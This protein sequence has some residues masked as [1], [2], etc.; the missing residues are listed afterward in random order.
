MLRYRKLRRIAVK[1]QLS[2][3]SRSLTV[4]VLALM[5]GYTEL[6]QSAAQAAY[7]YNISQISPVALTMEQLAAILNEDH[8]A[9]PN[10]PY[11]DTYQ[12]TTIND[13]TNAIAS[14][15]PLKVVQTDDP[16]H[17]YLGVFHN[18]VT[19]TEFA[20]FAAYSLDLNTWHTIGTID[21]VAAGEYGSQPDVRILPD[22]SVL[23]AEEYNPASKPQIRVRYY[24]KTG[25]RTGLQLFIADPGTVPS[26]EK[27]LPNIAFSK[28]EG[29]PDFGRI[30]YGG[31]VL[32]SKIEISHYSDFGIRNIQALGTLTTN[33]QTW[34]DTTHTTINN[35]NSQIWSDTTDTTIN[36]LV[37]NAG[38]NGKI[39][40]RDVF[41]AGSTAYE[42]V[43]AQVNPTSGND[44]GSWRLFLINRT[45]STIQKLSPILVGGAQSLGNPTV[46]FVT[47]PDG[48][49]ALVFTCFV[50]SQN[51]GTTLPGGHMFVYPLIN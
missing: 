15:A 5:L 45:T 7:D 32:S 31:S 27:I 3:L 34:S 49:P 39:G 1:A 41:R 44:F 38:G 30:D 29:G 12:Q 18:Q 43:E 8:S 36:N 47:L 19:T 11:L 42:V 13:T 48:R 50:F 51:S 22:E 37:T 33:F 24:G 26:Y 21:N 14:L 25:A 10:T 2:W 28:A 20:T 4:S 17:P 16:I 46:S 9:A 40:D 23:F 35:T 6:R